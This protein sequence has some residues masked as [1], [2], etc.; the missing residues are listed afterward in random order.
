MKKY[1]NV[2]NTI[3]AGLIIL[4]VITRLLPHLPNFSPVMALAIF[5]GFAYNDKKV[6]FI[7]PFVVMFISD[8]IIGFHDVMWAVY[9][10]FALGVFIGMILSKRFTVGGLFFSSIA[11]S[12][13]FFIITNF[14]FWLSY[15]NPS[16]A[17]L[18]KAYID[19]I[20]FFRNAT[21]GD[22]MYCTMLFGGYA[23]AGKFIPA[24]NKL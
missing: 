21:A 10:S 1:F 4:A 9:L 6:A 12:V 7:V 8:L 19:A 16:W 22:I 17:T 24:M 23:L 18:S 15:Y 5:G 11:G 13:L 2:R 14:E 3:T 20:P